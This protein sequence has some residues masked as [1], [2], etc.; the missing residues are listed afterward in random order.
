MLVSL[1]LP[2]SFTTVKRMKTEK[3]KQ[4]QLKTTVHTMRAYTYIKEK[5]FRPLSISSAQ[6]QEFISIDIRL[7]SI[8]QTLDRSSM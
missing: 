6:V 8:C 5:P 7:L 1:V 3:Q 2:S 4:Q